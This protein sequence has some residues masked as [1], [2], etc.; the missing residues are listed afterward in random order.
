MMFGDFVLLL[1]VL[2]ALWYVPRYL[3]RVYGGPDI[4]AWIVNT[5]Q[6]VMSRPSAYPM[7]DETDRHAD[8]PS[9][10]AD[11]SWIARLELD[12]SKAVLIE[13]LVYS[14]WQVGEIRA[15]VKGDNG[16][17]GVEVDAARK[18]LGVEPPE[19]RTPIAGRPTD[20]KFASNVN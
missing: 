9:V 2:V 14:G 17:I 18:R 7:A 11:D 8:R 13:L 12:R 10:S 4:R 16:A 3:W 6:P 5:F 20:A 1:S 15:V 19:L